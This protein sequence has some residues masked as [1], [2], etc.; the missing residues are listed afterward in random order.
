LLSN[1][2]PG[3][4]S[5]AHLNNLGV[6][7]ALRGWTDSAAVAF[8]G[9]M[10]VADPR[11]AGVRWGSAVDPGGASRSVQNS[12]YFSSTPNPVILNIENL[13]R[14]LKS[15]SVQY[16]GRGPYEF[17]NGLLETAEKRATPDE[18]LR[19]MAEV[20]PPIVSRSLSDALTAATPGA[21]KTPWTFDRA[22]RSI[23]QYKGKYLRSLD[24]RRAR[25]IAAAASQSDQWD[26]RG[27]YGFD[28][29][30]RLQPGEV[31]VDVYVV[32]LGD[33]AASLRRECVAVIVSRTAGGGPQVQPAGPQVVS[34]GRAAALEDAVLDLRSDLESPKGREVLAALAARRW[35]PVAAHLPAG[36]RRVWLSPD[37]RLGP[38]PWQALALS[39]SGSSAVTV[40]IVDSGE[41]IR[42][43]RSRAA[44]KSAKAL[45]VGN[46]EYG[47]GKLPA[48]GTVNEIKSVEEVLRSS[49]LQATVLTG[50]SVDRSR[51]LA[52]LPARILHFAT[53][54]EFRPAPTA[55]TALS[56]GPWVVL[57]A[58]LRT[59]RADNAPLQ[60]GSAVDPAALQR[61]MAMLGEQARRTGKPP[62]PEQVRAAVEQAQ[63][64]SRRQ[65]FTPLVQGVL[66]LSGANAV[67]DQFAPGPAYLSDADLAAADL[68]ATDLVV[69]SACDLGSSSQSAFQGLMSMQGAVVLAGARGLVASLWPVSND[70]AAPF[71]REFYHNLLTRK[72]PPADALREAQRAASVDAAGH[73]RSPF[74]WAGWMF[75]GEGW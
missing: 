40:S 7:L 5:S 44:T 4:I 9:A 60:R 24:A 14:L 73:P 50:A 68:S 64:G 18:R 20:F 46:L 49:G 42:E 55:V 34:L 22:Y 54:G 3:P 58:D 28:P 39:V 12:Q 43:P 45:L 56:V 26:D 27:L 15:G 67:A 57:D 75:F 69:L 36:T 62:T 65:A 29:A 59:A 74:L 66:A 30:S 8:S 47:A 70:D 23:A 37:G 19:A 10:L 6:A 61:Q 16:G 51:L 25:R 31:F 2:P 41:T 48:L 13:S 72:L 53:H 71:M 38:A 17:F 1:T 33:T 32:D 11:T 21:P 35:A 52:A 63:A